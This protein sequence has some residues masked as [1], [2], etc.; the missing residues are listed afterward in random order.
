MRKFI[1]FSY[2][3]LLLFEESGSVCRSTHFLISRIP[4]RQISKIVLF[5][6]AES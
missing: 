1:R 5:K 3:F 2:L 4:R 6:V